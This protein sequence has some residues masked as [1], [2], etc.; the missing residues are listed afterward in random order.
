MEPEPRFQAPPP[1]SKSFWLR[2]NSPGLNWYSDE[3]RLTSVIW[4]GAKGFNSLLEQDFGKRCKELVPKATN[5]WHSTQLSTKKG[6]RNEA[7]VAESDKSADEPKNNLPSVHGN[8]W[9]RGWRKRSGPRPWCR[10]RALWPGWCRS[11]RVRTSCAWHPSPGEAG[12]TWREAPERKSESITRAFEWD[13]GC[14]ESTSKL[15]L[16]TQLKYFTFFTFCFVE[17]T[18][19]LSA[20]SVFL[21]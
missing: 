3:W 17:L 7:S 1:P 11:G 16:Q 21:F 2:L 19:L 14:W 10:S 15:S 4:D 20:K 6:F 8:L 12:R 18:M 13:A 9:G 5:R